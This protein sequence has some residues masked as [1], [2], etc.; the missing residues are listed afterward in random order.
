MSM[1]NLSKNSINV[2]KSLIRRREGI[3]ILGLPEYEK[4]KKKI[5]KLEKERK[6]RLEEEKI[7]KLIKEGEREYREGKIKPI[8]SLK[9]LR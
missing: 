9:E 5:E 2:S 4:I 8:K 3:V 7:L 1:A 6:F